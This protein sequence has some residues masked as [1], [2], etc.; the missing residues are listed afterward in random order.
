MRVEDVKRLYV[1]N[2]AGQMLPLSTLVDVR[3]SLGPPYVARYNM[4]PTVAVNGEAAAGRST[5][6]ALQLMEQAAAQTLPMG[7]DYAWTGMAFQEKRVGNTA[8]IAF[9]LA[10]TVVYLVLA[11]QYESWSNPFAVILA[12]PTALFGAAAALYVR[13]MDVNLYTQIGLVLLVALSAKNAI[14]IVEFAREAR[15]KGISLPDAAVGGA[16]MRFR[17]ILMTSFAFTLGVFPLVI[18]T[19]AGA[20]SRQAL[21]VAV[22]GG[23][24][25]ATVFPIFFVPALY[26]TFQGLS[27]WLAARRS[28]VRN[29]GERARP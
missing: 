17:P 25:A 6:Q 26:V 12:V 5:G 28:K 13:G 20:A 22:V 11:A 15:A 18:A 19:G 8:V 10:V 4:F 9:L 23:M 24:L 2:E 3:E 14:L 27:E 21:G 16:K 29:S 1:R 7:M